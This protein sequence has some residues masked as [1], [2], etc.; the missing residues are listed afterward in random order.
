MHF[1]GN[2]GVSIE[3][4]VTVDGVRSVGVHAARLLLATIGKTLEHVDVV[5]RGDLRLLFTGG[6]DVIIHDSNEGSESYTIDTPKGLIV[7]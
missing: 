7:V 4:D 6:P 3:C 2:I 1:D 5:G